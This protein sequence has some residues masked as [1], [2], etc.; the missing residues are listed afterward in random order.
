MEGDA[1]HCKPFG[2]SLKKRKIYSDS[3]DEYEPPPVK[4]PKKIKVIDTKPEASKK[5]KKCQAAAEGKKL[6]TSTQS[7]TKKA[8]AVKKGKMM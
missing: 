5:R 4:R 8:D 3:E 1:V 2:S 7:T 6:K